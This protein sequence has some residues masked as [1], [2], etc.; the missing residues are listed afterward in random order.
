VHPG[1]PHEDYEH[2]TLIPT[3]L[4]IYSPLKLD[5]E[6]I[7]RDYFYVLDINHRAVFEIGHGLFGQIA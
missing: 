1:L 2:E 5:I 6:L 4:F 3:Q 7:F